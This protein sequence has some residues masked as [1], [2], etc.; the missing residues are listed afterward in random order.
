[1]NRT[2]IIIAVGLAFAASLSAAPAQAQNSRSFVSGLGLDANNCSL[3]TPCRSFQG[4][5]NKTNAGG[6]IDV[7][8]PAGYGALTI[9]HAISI[10][11][12]G[13]GTSSILV[14]SGGAGITINAGTGDAVSLRGLIIDGE[15]SGEFNATVFD[16]MVAH[17]GDIGF[18]ADSN[19]GQAPTTLMLFDSVAANN[20][21]GLTASG[22]GTTLRL[23][24]S[25]VTGNAEGW[26]AQNGGVLLSYADNYIDG[27][28]VNETAP[29]SIAQK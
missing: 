13:V 15:G 22:T 19:A 17:N 16:S 23:A 12:D 21:V 27:N 3:A 18:F 25:M 9:N 8:D 4:A 6:E 7:L 11:N 26:V 29:T 5:Y 1:M 10:V 28:A 14:P 24:Q 20:V 2:A